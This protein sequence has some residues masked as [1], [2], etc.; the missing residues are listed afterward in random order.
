MHTEM[1]APG[2]TLA[3]I[4][5]LALWLLA[6]LP[7]SSRAD[8]EA[9][10]DQA[11]VQTQEDD[12]SSDTPDDDTPP[13]EEIEPTPEELAAAEAPRV[14]LIQDESKQAASVVQ[15][16]RIL[17]QRCGQD[18]PE[19]LRAA[20]TGRA[21]SRAYRHLRQPARQRL[22]RCR[23]GPRCRSNPALDQA[24]CELHRDPIRVAA[25]GRIGRAGR[26]SSG[27]GTLPQKDRG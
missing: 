16:D 17:L 22:A 25:T 5:A 1:T 21:R 23:L 10:A 8:E 13:A 9:P 24:R 14:D 3:I 26:S 12:G 2:K 4:L 7:A 11:V 20:R 19:A 18:Q 15:G 27:D 6:A